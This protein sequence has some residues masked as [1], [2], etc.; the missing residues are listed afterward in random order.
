VTRAIVVTGVCG[1][2]KSAV[3]AAVAGRLGLPFIDA[4]DLH[5]TANKA[6]MAR[7]VPLD[8]ADRMPWLDAVA[9]AAATGDAVVACSALRRLHRDRLRAGLPDAF[10]VQLDV[11][12]AELERRV[13][14][15][16]HEFMP[17]TLLSSQLATLEPLASDEPG[18]RLPA[19]AELD[20]VVTAVVRELPQ[21]SGSRDSSA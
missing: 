4:D 12:R 8:D 7:G 15:R 5:P 10:F 21:Y 1:A 6:Q 13:R 2:G 9:G 17:P 3:G 11:S 16:S 20:D 14:E 18:L 19:D